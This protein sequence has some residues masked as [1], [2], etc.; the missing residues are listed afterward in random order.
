MNTLDIKTLVVPTRSC[1][2]AEGCHV[3]ATTDDGGI[4]NHEIDQKKKNPSFVCTKC[5]IT[6]GKETVPINHVEAIPKPTKRSRLE[7]GP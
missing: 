5:H 1:G 3:T 6:Y 4:L 7:L 2:G